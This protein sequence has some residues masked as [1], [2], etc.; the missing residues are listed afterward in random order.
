MIKQYRIK[1]EKLK[2]I[3]LCILK[4]M[5]DKAFYPDILLLSLYFL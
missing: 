3:F 5:Y 2:K 4:Y 1:F